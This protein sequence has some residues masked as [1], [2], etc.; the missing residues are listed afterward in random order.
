MLV[1]LHL[2][3]IELAPIMASLITTIQ[4]IFSTSIYFS[5]FRFDFLILVATLASHLKTAL[6][7]GAGSK[8]KTTGPLVASAMFVIS[9]VIAFKDQSLSVNFFKM[10]LSLFFLILFAQL[11]ASQGAAAS[12]WP[13]LRLSQL[14]ERRPRQGALG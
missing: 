11:S 2:N 7:R 1:P 5:C 14:S 4:I 8:P 3:L 9:H 6:E 13:V 12:T 10:I